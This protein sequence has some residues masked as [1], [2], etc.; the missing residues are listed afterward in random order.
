M[1]TG[2]TA[3]F[4]QSGR[5][6]LT[7]SGDEKK[8][9]KGVASAAQ[10]QKAGTLLIGEVLGAGFR[11]Y[12]LVPWRVEILEGGPKW[13]QGPVRHEW[14]KMEGDEGSWLAP[15]RTLPYN[16]PAPAPQP[17]V[18]AAPVTVLA[19]DRVHEPGHCS[20]PLS[21]FC[22]QKNL[23]HKQ[24]YRDHVPSSDLPPKCVDAT[25]LA[26]AA[27]EQTVRGDR[28]GRSRTETMLWV[29]SAV[30]TIL[31]WLLIAQLYACALVCKSNL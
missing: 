31:C 21:H 30:V 9:D 19:K 1:S 18:H 14:R 20:A 6:L 27:V 7:G 11:A 28:R 12:R 29:Y 24:L 3:P 23:H 17:P 22:D 13:P 8:L 25:V 15:V 10:R 5:L 4:D 26:I 2:S 16:V